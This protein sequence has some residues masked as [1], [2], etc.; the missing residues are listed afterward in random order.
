M[1]LWPHLAHPE[2]LPAA[3]EVKGVAHCHL[4]WTWTPENFDSV[5]EALKSKKGNVKN[6]AI[7]RLLHSKVAWVMHGNGSDIG[8]AWK[9][10]IVFLVRCCLP[11]LPERNIS[12]LS[13][14]GLGVGSA[15]SGIRGYRDEGLLLE[16]MSPLIWT[17]SI[18]DSTY[19][20]CQ[21]AFDCKSVL[22]WGKY[23]QK[24]FLGFSNSHPLN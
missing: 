20:F 17:G 9:S 23:G 15:D 16:R 11:A 24:A 21:S 19:F 1:R 2:L 3:Y 8:S 13:G 6:T 7:K 12:G 4:G 22:K 5:T 10:V 18:W 14:P